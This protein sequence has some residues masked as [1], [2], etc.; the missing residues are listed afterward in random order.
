MKHVP[1][2]HFGGVTAIRETAQALASARGHSLGKWEPLTE[3]PGWVAECRCGRLALIEKYAGWSGPWVWSGGATSKRCRVVGPLEPLPLTMA[4]RGAST[5]QPPQRQRRSD[6]SPAEIE[7]R[8][9]AALRE[10]RQLRALRNRKAPGLSRAE[11]SL[12][13]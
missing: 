12:D 1:R 6:Y 3:R 13:E 7:A 2:C 11:S 10:V 9:Q 8:Y 4:S 5:A